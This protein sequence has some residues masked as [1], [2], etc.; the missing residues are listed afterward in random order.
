MGH[1]M[2]TCVQQ[3]HQHDHDGPEEARDDVY[4]GCNH[5]E[6]VVAGR[7]PAGVDLVEASSI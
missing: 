4:R 6:D 7:G 5:G 1:H 2:I 3:V